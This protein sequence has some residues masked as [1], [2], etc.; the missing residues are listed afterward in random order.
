[1]D[2]PKVVSVSGMT[3]SVLARQ[4]QDVVTSLKDSGAPAGVFTRQQYRPEEFEVEE[5]ASGCLR[6]DNGGMIQ[7]KTSWA[8]NLP[9]EYY[10]RM[11]GTKAG[12]LLPEMKLLG[13]MGRY[14]TD[15]EPHVFAEE[16]PFA[17]EAFPGHFLLVKNALDHICSGSELLIKPEQTLHVTAVIEAFY[18][19]AAE[20]NEVLVRTE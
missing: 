11:A 18:R 10:M 19:S 17:S 3:S 8:V 4:E 12:V 20:G 1:M 13:V 5:F 14:Q 6:L 16:A 9:P 15:F 7:F 2:S